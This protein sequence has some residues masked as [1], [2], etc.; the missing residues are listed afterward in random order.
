MEKQTQK[1]VLQILEALAPGGKMPEKKS[2]ETL[3][4]DWLSPVSQKAL[5][6]AE[7]LLITG[8]LMGMN[9]AADPLNLDDE[10]LPLE[11]LQFEE[12]LKFFKGRVPLTKSEWNQIAPKVRFRAF[13]MARLGEADQIEAARKRLITAM[14]NGESWGKSYQ[15]IQQLSGRPGGLTPGYW[16]TV[17][18]TNTQTAYNAGRRMEF[19]RNPPAALELIVM[20]DERTSGICRPLK[21]KVLPYDHPFWKSNWPPFHFN[22][23]T[24][25]RAVSYD[26]A[27]KLNIEN[28][29]RKQTRRM[30]RPQKGFGG[31]PLEKESWWKMTP[32]MMERA[33][34]YG[35]TGEIILQARELDMRSYFPELLKNYSRSYKGKKGGYVN[36]A[37]NWEYSGVE[38]ESAQRL[39]DAGHKIY[40]LPKTHKASSPDMVIDNEIGEMK[41]ITTHRRGVI[42]GHIRQAGARQRARVLYIHIHSQ[43]QKERILQILQEE[44]AV[45]PIQR[46]LLDMNGIIE[47]YER[48]F[49]I[50]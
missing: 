11:P 29:G 35:I 3:N 27:K 2:L 44:I 34:K 21:G 31:N 12:A 15:E 30:F 37:K 49:F 9:H 36:S 24:T 6:I 1:D 16:E 25:V 10:P 7:E 14:E 47:N 18:R 22:C 33:E 50:K 17:Y 8:L 23:R 48:D 40:M 39:A 28:P 4:P 13:T 5:F 43:L 42:R 45:L 32:A 41:H 26:E 20:D 19:D 38:M 46:L